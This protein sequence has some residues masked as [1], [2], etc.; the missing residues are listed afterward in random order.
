MSSKGIKAGRAYTELG[1]DDSQLRRGLRDAQERL[2]RFSASVSRVGAS[3]AAA[4]TAGVAGFAAA[5]RQ[6]A[7][8]GDQINKISARTGLGAA[9][10]SELGFAAEQS[11]ASMELLETGVRRMQATVRSAGRGLSTSTDALDA[12]GLSAEKLAGVSPEQQLNMIAN[13]LAA[14]DDP[15]KRAAVAMEIFGRAGQRLV[16]LLSGGSAG[17]AKLRSEA[18]AL[19]LTVSDD[20]AAAAAELTDSMNRLA[21]TARDLVFEIGGALAPAAT[22]F[23]NKATAVA[24]AV[25]G[26]I[27]E[28]RGLVNIAA[29]ATLAI[30]GAGLALLTLG[31]AAA[32]ASVAVGGLV[33]LVGAITAATAALAG[34]VTSTAG[35]VTLAI[36][37]AGSA[38]LAFTSQGRT[39]LARLAEW[40]RLIGSVARPVLQ[41]ILDALAGGQFAAAARIA[42]L[43]IEIGFRT[44]FRNVAEWLDR[45]INSMVDRISSFATAAVAALVGL[46]EATGG[47]LGLSAES[48]AAAI[49]AISGLPSVSSNFAGGNL[50]ALSDAIESLESELAQI[51][52]GSGPE[53]PRQID[54][55]HEELQHLPEL[56]AGG[57]A[58]A[59]RVT[60]ASTFSAAAASQISGSTPEERAASAAERSAD[61]LE[62]INAKA[63]N[64]IAFA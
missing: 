5:T 60:A 58:A 54:R 48:G 49:G 34:I 39:A 6:F 28:N 47:R 24:S 43:G 31:G 61:L 37:A 42:G 45:L 40:F 38:L 50:V 27:Q 36:V 16:P 2:K 32:L 35:L 53:G 62:E 12:V 21:R 1:T 51:A 46:S 18:Q 57:L 25:A 7:G 41:G 10:V 44:A 56:I 11:G 8:Y 30:T 4:G 59:P 15:G 26:W 19:G 64:G 23:A 17:M 20:A 52:I 22:D 55:I 3:I 29:A 14:I 9:A 63:D 13:G 33:T